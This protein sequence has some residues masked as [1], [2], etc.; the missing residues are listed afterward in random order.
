MHAYAEWGEAAFARFD[1]MFALAMFD[2]PR[3]R[4]VLARDH[5]GIKPL[6]HARTADGGLLFASEVRAIVRSGQVAQEVD[7]ETV[8]DFLRFGSC[9][10]PRTLFAG[11]RAFPPGHWGSVHLD[12]GAPA[13]S[14][15]QRCRTARDSIYCT[16]G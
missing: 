1:G 14:G 15:A 9:Q 5:A 10:E 12:E 13:A 3:R 6:Y 8:A 2:G 11:I 7:V 4:L 16:R